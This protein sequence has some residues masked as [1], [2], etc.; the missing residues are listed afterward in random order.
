MKF[1]AALLTIA[2][3]IDL[4]GTDELASD[5]NTLAQDAT[6]GLPDSW[7]AIDD[8]FYD[9]NDPDNAGAIEQ[10][11]HILDTELFDECRFEYEC[12]NVEMTSLCCFSQV[13]DCTPQDQKLLY[14]A[15]MD[16]YLRTI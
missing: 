7:I 6:Q 4:Q 11:G 15:E 12:L 9:L 1:I 14:G 5:V 13:I 10:C 8:V 2:A 3:A 16:S